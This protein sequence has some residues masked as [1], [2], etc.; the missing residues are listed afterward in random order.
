[1]HHTL[2]RH[3]DDDTR[4][5]WIS[6]LDDEKGERHPTKGGLRIG[7]KLN[8]RKPDEPPSERLEWDRSYSSTDTRTTFMY[9]WLAL[10]VLESC[11]GR[12]IVKRF[13]RIA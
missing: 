6:G 11:S 8:E 2:G 4:N 12:F 13:G 7:K 5:G 9:S 3:R 10:M 1:M